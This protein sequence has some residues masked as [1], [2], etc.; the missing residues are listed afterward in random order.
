MIGGSLHYYMQRQQS[1]QTMRQMYQLIHY[2]GMK[3]V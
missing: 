1:Y 2:T 3:V